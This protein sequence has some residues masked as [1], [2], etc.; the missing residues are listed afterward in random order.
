MSRIVNLEISQVWWHMPLIP[1]LGISLE[2]VTNLAFCFLSGGSTGVDSHSWIPQLIFFFLTNIQNKFKGLG[3]R[4]MVI[5]G[6]FGP[7]N[8]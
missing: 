2:L 6:H 3:F 1:A 4:S 8:S 7:T 5:V